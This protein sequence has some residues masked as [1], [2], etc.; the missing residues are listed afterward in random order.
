[1]DSKRRTKSYDRMVL[2]DGQEILDMV[3]IIYIVPYMTHYH[4]LLIVYSFTAQ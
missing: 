3:S 2:V 4:C 1:M